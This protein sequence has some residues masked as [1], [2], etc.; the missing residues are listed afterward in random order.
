MTIVNASAPGKAVLFGEYVVLFGAPAIAAALNRRVRITLDTAQH[1]FHSVTAPGY[2]DGTW[3]FLQDRN[4]EIDWQDEP[5]DKSTFALLENIWKRIPMDASLRLSVNIDSNEFFAAAGGAKLGLG[6]SAAVSTALACALSCCTD[7]YADQADSFRAAK[8][9]HR[10]F[11]DGRGSGVDIATSFYGGLLEFRKGSDLPPRRLTWPGDLAYRFLWSGHP[12]STTG[13]LGQ[14]SDTA[15][16]REST[17]VLGTAAEDI[18][19]I[20]STGAVD[21]IMDSIR[22]YIEALRQFDVDHDLGIFDAGHAGLVEVAAAS[23]L[24]YKPCGAGGGDI[25]VVF[26]ADEESVIEF[27]RQA[28][29]HDF[30]QLDLQ[31]DAQ[32]AQAGIEK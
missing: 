17:L 32:G 27:C 15:H 29:K 13:K 18:A 1:D 30:E 5:P 23:D 12:A 20:W 10:A 6:S 9:A 26:G 11:Q 7:P 25:G 19:S 22:H 8:E 4:G 2:V 24:G 31:P 3:R 14:L 21:R 28:E 16:S